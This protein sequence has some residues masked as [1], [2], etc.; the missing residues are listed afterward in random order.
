MVMLGI[1]LGPE[2]YPPVELLNYAVA[3]EQAG[4]DAIDV[5]DH[6]HPW[7]ELGQACFTWTWLGAAAARTNR[8]VLGPGVTC[9]ILRYHPAVIAQASATVDNFAPGR[10]YLGL[11]TGEALNEYAA[12][13]VWPDYSDRQQM[14][15]EAIE[16]IRRLWA[17]GYVTF[18]GAFY[19]TRKA[20]LYTPPKTQIPIIIS[21]L[22]PGSASF[23]G[24]QGDGLI[25][26][27]NET[28]VLKQILENFEAGSRQAGKDP[29][30]MSK[31]I[32]LNVIYT[33]DLQAVMNDFKKYWA[34]AMIPAM[35]NQNIY[36]P[37]MSE[38]NGAVVGDDAL[39]KRMCI[40]NDPDEH[41]RYVQQFIDMGF[42]HIYVHTAG[43]GQL[44]FIKSYTRDVLPALR[45]Q[46]KGAAGAQEA[47]A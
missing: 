14:L 36:T 26:V 35:F 29:D 43:P 22:V 39:M 46:N 47:T 1:K 11:G 19:S 30:T 12:T 4:F 21:S 23:A 45:E 27:S 38:M 32:E 40:S 44:D 13:G 25:T 7:S 2:E 8:I 20:K 42:T 34:G 5:S 3:A 28:P 10:T 17:G 37:S 16:L 6:F 24:L 9:P 31:M 15:F 41:I 18:D 33:S